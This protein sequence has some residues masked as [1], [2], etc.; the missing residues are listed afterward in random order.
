METRGTA[1]QL[2]VRRRRAIN[3]TPARRRQCRCSRVHGW[4]VWSPPCPSNQPSTPTYVP[5][6]VESQQEG[7]TAG[8]HPAPP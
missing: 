8:W 3:G 6:L 1:R 7:C 5:L 2:C 4:G